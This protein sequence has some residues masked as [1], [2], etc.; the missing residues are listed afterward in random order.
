M[1]SCCGGLLK[2]TALTLQGCTW[3]RVFDLKQSGNLPCLA[4]VAQADAE[5][6]ARE[7][8]EAK[9]QYEEV[10]KVKVT[11]PDYIYTHLSR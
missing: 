2:G 1:P 11:L 8:W 5:T 10:K 3:W 4:C 7:I 9:Q 6:L